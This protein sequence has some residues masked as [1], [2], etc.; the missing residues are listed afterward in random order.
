MTLKLHPPNMKLLF[1]LSLLVSAR[2]LEWQGKGQLRALQG[3][4]MENRGSDQGCIT[5]QGKWTVNEA[6]CDLFSGTRKDN[7]TVTVTTSDG[8]PCGLDEPGNARFVCQ[9]GMTADRANWMVSSLPRTHTE[10]TGIFGQ[11]C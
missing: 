2:A 10:Q 1:F 6:Q 11:Y 8:V 9:K 3:W 7:F 4:P 5:R